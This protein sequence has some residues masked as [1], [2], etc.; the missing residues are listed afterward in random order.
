MRK[1]KIGLHEEV[2]KP[3]EGEQTASSPALLASS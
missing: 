1:T 2:R 3:R